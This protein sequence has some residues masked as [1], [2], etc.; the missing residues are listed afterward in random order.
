MRRTSTSRTRAIS[1]ETTTPRS[2]AILTT[3]GLI[4]TLIMVWLTAQ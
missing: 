1:A 4:T 3:I 2:T